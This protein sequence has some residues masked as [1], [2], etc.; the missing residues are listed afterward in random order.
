MGTILKIG[1]GRSKS[2]KI[3]DRDTI[4]L[5]LNNGED[6]NKAAKE[7][8]NTKKPL[9][10]SINEKAYIEITPTQFYQMK[11]KFEQKELDIV[12]T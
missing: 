10:I 6:Y 1:L 2:G 7:V 3:L 11:E 5:N 8:D 9:F 12:T 4:W